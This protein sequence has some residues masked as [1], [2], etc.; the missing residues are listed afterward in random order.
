MDDGERISTGR[1]GRLL[2]DRPMWNLAAAIDSERFSH[3]QRSTQ[4]DLKP[5]KHE[6]WS[7]S[8]LGLSCSILTPRFR[9]DFDTASSGG[10]N[11]TESPT[12]TVQYCSAKSY[13]DA[14][15]RTVP[16]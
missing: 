7:L 15:V 2:W 14:C 16:A 11:P 10:A 6:P 9:R 3:F 12:Q 8:P 13:C 1:R 5:N 4:G